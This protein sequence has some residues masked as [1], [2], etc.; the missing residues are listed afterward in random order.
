MTGR[1]Y[2]TAFPP[3]GCLVFVC[4][5]FLCMIRSGVPKWTPLPLCYA[6]SAPRSGRDSCVSLPSC[7]LVLRGGPPSRRGGSNRYACGKKAA[8]KQTR[9]SFSAEFR[10]KPRSKTLYFCFS[11]FR[12]DGRRDVAV[13][14]KLRLSGHRGRA[15]WLIRIAPTPLDRSTSLQFVGGGQIPPPP[16]L[17]PLEHE[18]RCGDG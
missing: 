4:V 1:H 13:D 7:D 11:F 2:I 14:S 10:F 8:G 9:V 18:M 6:A 17:P 12:M 3:F 16:S 5:F 15:R